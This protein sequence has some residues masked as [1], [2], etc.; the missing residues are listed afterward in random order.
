VPELP[1]VETTLR[2]IEPYILNKT[3]S[4]II[5]RQA[6]L[7]WPVPTELLKDKLINILK[8]KF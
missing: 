3:I 2:G 5:V 7:R 4:S 1:E 6:S 8:I